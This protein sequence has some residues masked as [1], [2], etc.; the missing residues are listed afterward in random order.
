MI[1]LEETNRVETAKKIVLQQ[2]VN[3]KRHRTVIITQGAEPTI[4]ATATSEGNV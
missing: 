3:T 4:V 2:K 1:G